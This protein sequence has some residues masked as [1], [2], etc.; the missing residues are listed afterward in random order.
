MIPQ[1]DCTTPT[2]KQ[3]KALW[4]AQR[5][6]DTVMRQSSDTVRRRSPRTRG[7]RRLEQSSDTVRRRSARTNQA[8][9]TV[10]RGTARDEPSAR[11]TDD[12]GPVIDRAHAGECGGICYS[13]AIFQGLA[14][15][16]HASQFLRGPPSD[17]HKKFPLYHAFASVMNAMVRGEETVVDPSPFVDLY[18]ATHNFTDAQGNM[19][20]DS[21]CMNEFGNVCSTNRLFILLMLR[22]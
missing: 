1:S 11:R 17:A 2:K 3:I 12:P 18:R 22:E 9:R 19:F 7:M 15:C 8:V 21:Q 6:A 20:C 10:R 5:R 14:S 4:Q 13:N 16:I